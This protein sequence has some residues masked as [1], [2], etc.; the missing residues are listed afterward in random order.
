MDAYEENGFLYRLRQGERERK[1]RKKRKKGRKTERKLYVHPRF[2][3]HSLGSEYDLGIILLRLLL[4]NHHRILIN[5]CK[6]YISS[7]NPLNCAQLQHTEEYHS[8][9]SPFLCGCQLLE[10]YDVIENVIIGVPAVA[11]WLANPT[12]NHGVAG[13]IPGLAQ[14]VGDPVLP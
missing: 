5:F 2:S 11:Q 10:S 1:R 13:L 8:L 14:W 6:K 3:L 9:S 12:G 4:Y 7:K